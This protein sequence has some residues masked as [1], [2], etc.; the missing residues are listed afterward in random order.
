MNPNWRNLKEDDVV[1]Y[2]GPQRWRVKS[3]EKLDE[4]RVL[5]VGIG[6][7]NK[8]REILALA[9]WCEKLQIKV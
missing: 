6:E 8:D 2:A 5:L 3:V 1:R 9:E 4:K 7:E